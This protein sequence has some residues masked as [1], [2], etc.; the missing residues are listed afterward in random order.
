[1]YNLSCSGMTLHIS[2]L[3]CFLIIKNVKEQY[4]YIGH[5][6]KVNYAY[7]KSQLEG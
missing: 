4:V 7:L 6:K 1:M 5:P 2:Y 3:Y